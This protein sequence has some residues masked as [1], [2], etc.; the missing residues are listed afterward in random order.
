M[1][2]YKSRETIFKEKI[3]N[4]PSV[5]CHSVG[6]CEKE[7]NYTTNSLNFKLFKNKNIKARN[8]TL[9]GKDEG[10]QK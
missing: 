4:V 10:L 1:E 2:V 3:Y 8:I 7:W 6:D 5:I 9:E